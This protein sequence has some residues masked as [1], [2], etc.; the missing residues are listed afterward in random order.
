MPVCSLL[1]PLSC[2]PQ[3]E[4]LHSAPISKVGTAF[5]T[6]PEVFLSEHEYDGKVTGPC[7]TA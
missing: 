1:T 2:N 6:A 3:H 4:S 7:P 5:Y